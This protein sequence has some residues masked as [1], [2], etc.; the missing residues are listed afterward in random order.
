[1]SDTSPSSNRSNIFKAIFVD[2]P[3]SV[4]ET[5]F[6]HM[7]FAL[8]FSFWLGAACLAALVHAFIPAAFEKTGS[9]IIKR[10]HAKIESRD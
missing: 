6:E 9:N 2:H 1:M 8:T 3:A 7:K 10:L 5:Y 4:D